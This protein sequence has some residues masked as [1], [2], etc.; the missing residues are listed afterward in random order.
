VKKGYLVQVTIHTELWIPPGSVG[1]ATEARM[2]AEQA[3]EGMLNFVED[4]DR[5]KDPNVDFHKDWAKL[6]VN[7]FRVEAGQV[8]RC[9][10]EN[11][12]IDMSR[13]SI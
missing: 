4:H 6:A 7:V 9:H 5:F 13:F 10:E 8:T 2:A 1:N 3:A 12:E 11:L